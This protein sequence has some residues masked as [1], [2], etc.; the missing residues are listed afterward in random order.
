MN[1]E[2]DKAAWD[3]IVVGAGPAGLNAA[4][5]LGRARRRVVVLDNAQPR[6]YATHEMHGV[7]GHDG[8]DPADLRARG[9]AELTRYGVE[10]VSAEA[11][12]AEV[13]DGLVRVSST[14]GVDVTRSV[15]LATGML[16]ELPNLP[17]FAGVWGTSAHTCPYCDGFEHRDER[18]AV[19][20]SGD[21]GQHLALLLRQWSG[22]VVLLSNGPHDLG[23]DQL[24]RLDARGIPIIETPVAEL[25]A[26]KDGRLRRVRLE[27]GQ[28]I[29]RDALFFYVGW[30]LRND[31]ARTLGCQLRTDGSVAVDSEQ[32]T[33]VD[34]VYA[35]GNCAEPRA[36]VP[37]ATGSGVTAAV[38]IN[39]RLSLED[40]DHAVA[41]ARVP[42]TALATKPPNR[43][44]ASTTR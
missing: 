9:R 38:A 11:Q 31:L 5:V 12:D 30:E 44:E 2:S 22:D 36:L 42:A 3:C 25:D 8:V 13:L 7:L 29:D 26:D 40:A 15:L 19:L 18:I 28:T 37:T 4:L 6:N 39:V 14:R 23:I 17:G 27:N 34:R 21:R 32:A 20:A 33:S 24:A 35:A 43:P 16:D 1:S 10:V 41:H